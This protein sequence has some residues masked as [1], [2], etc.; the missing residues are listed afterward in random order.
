M[1]YTVRT[2]NRDTGERVAGATE[3]TLPLR[4]EVSLF[5]GR[6]LVRSFSFL[7]KDNRNLSLLGE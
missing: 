2:V 6:D 7:P 1:T 4:V 3:S 5:R